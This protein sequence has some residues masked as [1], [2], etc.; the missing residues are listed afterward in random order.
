[1]QGLCFHRLTLCQEGGAVWLILWGESHLLFEEVYAS[2]EL[3]PVT[4]H[5]YRY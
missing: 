3:V 2:I 1:M 5:Y 4:M